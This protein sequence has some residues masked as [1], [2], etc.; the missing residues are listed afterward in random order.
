MVVLIIFTSFPLPKCPSVGYPF[1]FFS[2]T[3]M[4][5]HVELIL[6]ENSP[7]PTEKNKA[8]PCLN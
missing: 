1:F 5:I 7:P 8:E 4:L 2:H 6:I 3:C